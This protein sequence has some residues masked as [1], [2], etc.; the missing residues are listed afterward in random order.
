MSNDNPL[1]QLVDS[2]AAEVGIQVDEESYARLDRMA[3]WD[4]RRIKKIWS[5][6]TYVD[7][8]KVLL[9]ILPA[10]SAT[11][12]EDFIRSETV[13]KDITQSLTELGMEVSQTIKTNF[14]ASPHWVVRYLVEGEPVGNNFIRPEFEREDFTTF[15]ITL[16]DKLNTTTGKIDPK[17]LPERDFPTKWLKEYNDRSAHVIKHLGADADGQ[18]RSAIANVKDTTYE[19]WL[20]H[21]DLA[22]QNILKTRSGYSLIDWGEA[23]LGPRVI[24]WAMLWSFAIDLPKLQQ[25]IIERSLSE[26]KQSD[27]D[28][29]KVIFLGLAARM[30]AS[31]AEWFEHYKTHQ[32]EADQFPR[33]ANEAFDALPKIWKNFQKLHTKFTTKDR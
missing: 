21:N 11:P 28:T 1:R 8:R 18:L 14:A 15:L 5:T 12:L 6:G 33:V 24:D 30:V 4:L 7:G 20:L 29:A 9:K 22:P 27:Q 17:L 13:E 2:V 3:A 26:V 16:R 23:T 32:K 19:K 10:N 25:T 31:F